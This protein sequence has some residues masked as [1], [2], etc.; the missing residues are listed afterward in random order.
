VRIARLLLLFMAFG[1]G[2]LCCDSQFGD[3]PVPAS[4]P[5]PEGKDLRIRQ[6]A[7]PESP[8]RAKPGDTVAVSGA[9]VVAVDTFD[10]T[11]NGKSQGTI[12]VADMGSTEGYS[13]ISLF[14]PSW[15]PGNLRV[16]AGDALDL[17]GTYQENNSVPIQFA[18][19]SFLVQLANPIGTFRFEA[20][21]PPPV[22]L[23]DVAVL[24]KYETGRPY[25]NMIVT[26][27]DVTVQGDLLE[28]PANGRMSAKLIP[29]DTFQDFKVA[30]PKAPTI[31]N[32]L[33]DLAPLKIAKGTKLKSLT[34]IVTFF[35]NLH[36][37]PRTADD[38]VI[39]K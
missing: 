10:E 18:P 34:G 13:G 19:D 6:I 1:G 7:N 23:E 20:T 2:L 9:V 32:E 16:G 37:A 33:M 24:G 28:A 15:V 3:A 36:I 17:R 26:V 8:N 30:G 25:L 27:H 39:D 35:C 31:V 12:Y 14:N 11:H 5:N 4:I 29:E 22:E 38:V 21:L